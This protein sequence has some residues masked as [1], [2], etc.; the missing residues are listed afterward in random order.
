MIRFLQT[1]SPAKKIVFGIILVA[2]CLILAISLVPSLFTDTA[3]SNPTQGV[4]ATVGGE[5]ITS[6]AVVRTAQSM[7]QRQGFPAQ[8]ANFLVPRALDQAISEKAELL[9]AERMGFRASDEEVRDFLKTG[10]L[11]QQLFPKGVFIGQKEY[12]NFVAEQFRVS[13]PEFETQV[14]DFLLQLKLSS[15]IEQGVTVADADVV[16]A[17]QEDNLKVKLEYAVISAGDLEKNVKATESE[18]RAYFDVHKGQYAAAAPEKRKLEYFFVSADKLSGTQ[19]T[20]QEAQA[21]YSAHQD[22]F[23][24]DEQVKASHILIKVPSGADAKT[25]QAAKAKIEGILQQLRSGAD[26]AEL[27]KK[28]SEDTTAG[29]GG[30][31]GWF[32]HGRM[33]APFDQA[34]FSTNKGQV[35]GIVKTQF[36]YHIIK[37]DDKRAAGV[38]SFSDVKDNLMQQ[39]KANK[40]AQ[41]VQYAASA[42]QNQART[43]GM[44]KAAAGRGTQVVTT[45]LITHDDVL[46]GIGTSEEF[47]GAAFSVAPKSPPV[48]VQLPNGIAVVQV[49]EAQ[50]PVPP[51]FES[52]RTQVETQFKAERAQQLLSQ[53][54]AE[55]ADKARA[56]HDLKAAA[57]A[58]GA[59]VKTSDV[60]GRN[61]QAPDIGSMQGQA[62]TA[63]DMK[64]GEISGP[65]AGNQ[66]GIVFTVI[67]RH[68]A[69]MDEFAS[70]KDLVRE[71]VLSRKRQEVM[72]LY[73]SNLVEQLEKKGKITKNKTELERISKQS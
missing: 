28:N 14:R 46:P 70:K 10:N 72:A 29:N 62:A 55:L 71:Q 39:L 11:G 36:G 25:D 23:K 2:F 20:E 41:A 30:S 43:E 69:S 16:K 57:K 26:F 45:G 66:K 73:L 7:A 54:T 9:E 8:F 17:Y 33:V 65:V 32:G 24:T 31:L 67:E 15:L 38:Q 48:A 61:G 68:E 18:L 56:S 53:K 34:A 1:P 44:A 47:M 21:Y 52:M 12:E 19:V 35:S 37:V 49:D 58:L 42:V 59:T 6:E 22:A 50:A 13:V 40:V 27:A 4:V 3:N 5:S 51:T 64:P 60:V 63:F